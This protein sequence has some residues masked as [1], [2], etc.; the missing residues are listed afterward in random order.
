MPKN[1]RKRTSRASN[2][3]SAQGPKGASKQSAARRKTKRAA[4][5][6]RSKAKPTIPQVVAGALD[7]LKATDVSV[8]DV[9]HLTTVTD[10]MIVAS[11]RSD[12]HVRAIADEVVVQCK[13][14][15]YR[16]I[17]VEGKGTGEWV[18]VDLGDVVVH[19]MQ[20]RARE[21]YNLE[22]LWDM[23]AVEAAE[24]AESATSHA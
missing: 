2:P 21:F 22:K 13:K 7:D 23:T 10:T 9:R 5:R 19:V 20:P 12:R 17:G 24:V 18:L 14:E 4:P 6:A 8:L 15:G 16:P 1:L 3:A 11:G